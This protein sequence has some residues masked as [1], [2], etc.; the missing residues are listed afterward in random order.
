MKAVPDVGGN[1]PVKMDLS[2][3]HMETE[4]NEQRVVQKFFFICVAS[5]MVV[6]FPA[7]LWPRKAVI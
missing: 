2:V 3:A 5:Y 4:C 6:V 1:M 7:P